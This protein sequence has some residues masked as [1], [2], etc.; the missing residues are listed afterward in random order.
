[1]SGFLAPL[2]SEFA[3]RRRRLRKALGDARASI[4]EF[5]LLAGIGF[6][7]AAPAFARTAFPGQ[8]YAPFLPAL[9]V[10]GYL[11]IETARQ[12]ALTAAGEEA[13]V[14][15]TFDRR[16]LLF[17]GA[18]AL[19]GVATLAWAILAVPPPGFVPDTPPAD[20]LPVSIG[21]G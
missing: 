20:A 15:N 8:A 3:A 1:M 13:S 18:V 21:P 11:L 5:A 19:V 17:L 6:G 10:A 2:A 16:V 7:F 9:A 4:V 14:T 12:R